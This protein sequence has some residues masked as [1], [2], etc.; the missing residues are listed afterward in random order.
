MFLNFRSLF[1]CYSRIV[2]TSTLLDHKN[3][4]RGGNKRV[5]VNEKLSQFNNRGYTREQL[6]VRKLIGNNSTVNH[7]KH[8]GKHVDGSVDIKLDSKMIKQVSNKM[9]QTFY[10]INQ[11][12]Q[13]SKAVVHF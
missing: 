11:N 10:V 13:E 7:I 6:S 4:T 2:A 3:Q 1:K 8:I 9:N 12:Y 5:F